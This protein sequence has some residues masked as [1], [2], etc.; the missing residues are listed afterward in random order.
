MFSQRFLNIQ[1]FA[2][3][4][5]QLSIHNFDLEE[6]GA[7]VS[8]SYPILWYLSY[9]GT[10]L[11]T[12]RKEMHKACRK[13]KNW[14]TAEQYEKKYIQICY[15]VLTADPARTKLNRLH[16]GFQFKLSLKSI[17]H[18]SLP[19]AYHLSWLICLYPCFNDFAAWS[20][21]DILHI[22]YW[23]YTN[24]IFVCDPLPRLHLK[25]KQIISIIQSAPLYD[26]LVRRWLANYYSPPSS[27]RKN[28]MAFVHI[29]S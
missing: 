24:T 10:F 7:L 9:S 3:I 19:E 26:W 20:W 25:N 23:T 6:T 28:K 5:F 27:R 13:P 17:M 16:L 15:T 4:F 8:L 29:L 22:L 1:N 21:S 12:S 2:G 18:M 11:T 14:K